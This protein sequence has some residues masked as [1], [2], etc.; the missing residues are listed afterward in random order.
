MDK[1]C[2]QFRDD[3]YA[4]TVLNIDLGIEPDSIVKEVENLHSYH[5]INDESYFLLM[6]FF[7]QISSNNLH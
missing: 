3:Y 4:I 6:D 7:E 1:I 5:R 2:E